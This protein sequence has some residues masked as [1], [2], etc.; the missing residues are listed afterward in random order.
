MRPTNS[1]TTNYQPGEV[2]SDVAA[3][4]R[5][6]REEMAKIKAAI[7]AVADGFAPVVYS[8]PAKPREG[9]FRNADGVQWNP[10]S[11]PGLYRF[12]GVSWQFL[13]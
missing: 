2:P 12:D 10:G 9:M 5:F 13:G 8:P 7:D 1:N 11:G 3:I 6:L 4:P